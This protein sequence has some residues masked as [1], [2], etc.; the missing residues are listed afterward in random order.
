MPFRYQ[1]A[2][3][4]RPHR[5]FSLVE[6]LVT[7]AI[8]AALAGL[9]MSA[10]G[11]AR[12]AAWQSSCQNNLRNSGIALLNYAGARRELPPGSETVHGTEFAWSAFLLPYLEQDSLYGQLQLQVRWDDP[13]GNLRASLADVAIYKC[14][15]SV[16][17]FP[18]KQDYGGV[19]GTTLTGL[20]LGLDRNAASG[21]G[22]LITTTLEQSNPVSLEMIVD[23]LSRTLCVGESVDRDPLGAGRWACGQNCFTQI[24]PRVNS[25][26]RGDL[27]SHHPGGANGLYVDGHVEFLT[28]DMDAMVLGAICT[29]G[30]REIGQGNLS[31]G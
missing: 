18:G 24:A 28:L 9:L 3:L 7:I 17:D 8:L 25:G 29:R 26:D 21:C 5:G 1:D 30:G 11:A 20:P 2:M 14:P 6:L 13:R 31:G 27:M 16:H 19:Q 15:G 12:K 22:T 23:G 10:V 4:S